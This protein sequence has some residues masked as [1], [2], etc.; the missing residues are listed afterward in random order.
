MNVIFQTERLQA[1][2]VDHSNEKHV[3]DLY[4]KKENV[5]FLE[6]IDVEADIRLS[7]E[8]YDAYKKFGSY[9][10][11]ENKTDK[12]I[13]FGG[14]QKQEPMADGSLALTSHDVE[15]L[16]LIDREAVGKGYA[17]EFCSAFF[18]QLFNSFS[19]L[20]VPARVDKKNSSCIGLLKK[21][22]FVLEG[23]IDYHIYGNK[24]FLFRLDFALFHQAIS[25]KIF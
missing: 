8:C 7:K 21:L 18:S 24:F 23:E 17:Y 19:N 4:S 10:I 2:F 22:G 11:F 15:F 13:G 25:R 5:E 6:G 9:L 14:I 1:R 12:F 16:I 3:I 20:S